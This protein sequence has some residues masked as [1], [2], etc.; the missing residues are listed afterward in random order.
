MTDFRA[1]FEDDEIYFDLFLSNFFRITVLNNDG[2]SIHDMSSGEYQFFGILNK[3]IYYVQREVFGDSSP[4][5]FVFVFDEPDAYLH[6][7]WVRRFAYVLSEAMKLF[8]DF[9]REKLIFQCIITTHSPILL[10]DI[11]LAYVNALKKDKEEG[12]IKADI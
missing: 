2:L 6:P 7:E 11:P 10:S 12:I 3:F 5:T 4:K 1:S 8:G 9:R